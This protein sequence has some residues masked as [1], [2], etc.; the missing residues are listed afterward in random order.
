M[1]LGSTLSIW[2]QLYAFEDNFIMNFYV[3]SAVIIMRPATGKMRVYF[4][5]E[6][7]FDV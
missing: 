7:R 4:I 2:V 3:M 5:F 6:A 1:H